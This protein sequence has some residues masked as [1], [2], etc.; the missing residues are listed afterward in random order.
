MRSGTFANNRQLRSIRLGENRALTEID[1]DVLEPLHHLNHLD[2]AFTSVKHLPSLRNK[3]ELLK[4][5]VPHAQLEEI[6]ADLCDNCPS[7]FSLLANNNSITSIPS[8]TNC[9]NLELAYLFANKIAN[10]SNQ[11]FRGQKSLRFIRLDHNI[12]QALPEHAFSHLSSLRYLYLHYNQIRTVERSTFFN[13]TQLQLLALSFNRIDTLVSDVFRD[14]SELEFLYINDNNLKKISQQAFPSSMEHLLVLDASNNTE[15]DHLPVPSNGFPRLYLLRLINLYRL[16]N[17]PTPEQIPRIEF[18]NFTYSYS[19]CVFKK[20]IREDQLMPVDS[21]TTEPPPV[22]GTGSSE[23]TDDEFEHL[24]PTTRPTATIDNSDLMIDATAGPADNS[25]LGLQGEVDELLEEHNVHTR[26]LP[27]GKTEFIINGTNGTSQ[28]LGGTD[29]ALLALFNHKPVPRHRTPSP[30]IIC[31]PRPDP[32]SP[33]ENLLGNS[34]VLRALIWAVW[35]IAIL[36]NIVV[37]FVLA[38]GENVKVPEFII[39]NL[40]VADFLMGVYL[41]FLAIVDIRTFG[42]SSFFKSALQWQKGPGCQS[43]GFFAVLSSMQSVYVLV[44]ITLERLQTVVYSFNRC[45]RMKWWHAVSLVTVGWVFAG[46]MA[47]LPL[48]EVGI[49]SYTNV[50]VCLPIRTN[51]MGDKVYLGIILGVNIISFLIILGSYLHMFLLFL[52]SPA[53]NNRTRDRVCTAWKMAI[54]VGTTLVCWLPLTVVGIS[55]LIGHPLIDLRVAKFFIVIILPINACLNPFLYAFVTQHFRD[56]IMGICQRA[57]RSIHS[58]AP[59]RGGSTRRSSLPFANSSDNSSIRVNSPRTGIN[60]DL[61]MLRQTRRCNSLTGQL[62]EL[63]NQPTVPLTRGPLPNM[64]RRNSSPAI[65]TTPNLPPSPHPGSHLPVVLDEHAETSFISPEPA[66]PVNCLSVVHEEDCE[67][68]EEELCA[69]SYTPLNSGVTSSDTEERTRE[70]TLTA[71]SPAELQ[72]ASPPLHICA[73]AELHLVGDSRQEPIEDGG[74]SHVSD[75][76][77]SR[78]TDEAGNRSLRET[79][80]N[81]GLKGDPPSTASSTGN[82]REP[83]RIIN[84]HASR[85]SHHSVQQETDV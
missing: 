41:A 32:L 2:M 13:T 84:P 47:T 14:A 73:P 82:S 9:T 35:V 18:I 69:R 7:L 67:A 72:A 19:C 6:P 34:S 17:V 80:E 23:H 83:I 30:T 78:G 61:V 28:I 70:P 11:P 20:F 27:N 25:M 68:E 51:T 37:L 75:D 85:Q 45:T 24:P 10:L 56:R 77:G 76:Q 4:L 64:G 81:E 1:D 33:C 63:Y 60:M 22:P 39:C 79:V 53:A 21:T 26:R 66:R 43:A 31:Y 16:F 12:I 5:H 48:L 42:S 50:A 29:E 74:D 58:G 3:S 62:G 46:V 71:S 52:K 36:G 40:A 65:F 49:N 55:G 57:S 59:T 8:L 54:L 44:I 38:S 15:L